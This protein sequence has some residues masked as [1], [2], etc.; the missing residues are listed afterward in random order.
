MANQSL[1]PALFSSRLRD[2]GHRRSLFG[3]SDHIHAAKVGQSPQPH[4]GRDKLAVEMFLKNRVT[5]SKPGTALDQPE[6]RL[7]S[8][9]VP[10]C[11]V[12]NKDDAKDR[13]LNFL[14]SFS[15]KVPDLS[16]AEF[17]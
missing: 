11:V 16:R 10:G 2:S 12:L 6:P 9:R 1:M 5:Q 8:S 7:A 14:N 3:R 13:R 17:L 4:A 15:P